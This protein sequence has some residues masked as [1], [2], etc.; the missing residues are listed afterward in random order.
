MM[1]IKVL[2]SFSMVA[3]YGFSDLRDDADDD[4]NNEVYE[5]VSW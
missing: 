1:M 2:F 5:S 4:S 3:H